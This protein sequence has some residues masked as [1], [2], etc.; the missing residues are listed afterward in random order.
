MRFETTRTYATL[1]SCPPLSPT[2]KLSWKLPKD[3]LSSI[4]SILQRSKASWIF[5]PS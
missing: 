5:K 2:V 3:N 4:P 1:L